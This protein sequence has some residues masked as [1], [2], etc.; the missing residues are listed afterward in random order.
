M[1]CCPMTTQ[2]KG[3]PFEDQGLAGDRLRSAIRIAWPGRTQ[4]LRACRPAPEAMPTVSCSTGCAV[5]E[6][7]P[8]NCGVRRTGL[9]VP[10]RVT[11][12][13]CRRR[14]IGWQTCWPIWSGSF[15][16]RRARPRLWSGLRWRTPSSKPFT[17]FSMAMAALDAC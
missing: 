4:G 7:S 9:V 11:P 5:Q 6:S 10:V 2:I 1:V 15:T 16:M 14:R 8:V 3:Y 13:L 17:P 12:H